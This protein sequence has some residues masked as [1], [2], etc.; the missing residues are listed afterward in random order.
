MIL[1]LRPIRP[2]RAAGYPTNEWAPELVGGRILSG[3]R[4]L[5]Y[6]RLPPVPAY[7]GFGVFI[8]IWGICSS[9]NVVGVSYCPYVATGTVTAADD[10]I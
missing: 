8:V 7:H 4:G 3:K 6:S 2:P 10:G 5:G 9:G 1:S